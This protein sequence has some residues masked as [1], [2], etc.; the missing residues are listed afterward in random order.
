VVRAA[1]SSGMWA[2]EWHGDGGGVWRA[3]LRVG[4]VLT[5]GHFNHFKVG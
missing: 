5:L 3:G 4:V 1:F 2:G